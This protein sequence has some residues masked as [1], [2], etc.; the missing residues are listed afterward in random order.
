MN[1]SDEL[2]RLGKL[3]QQG[4]LTEEEFAQAKSKLLQGD[5]TPR[6]RGTGLGGLLQNPSLGDAANRYISYRIV[7]GVIGLIIFLI[8]FFAFFLPHF[9]AVDRAFQDFPGMRIHGMPNN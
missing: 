6:D 2:E 7:T 5:D 1:L 9:R 4:L 3:R 8:M